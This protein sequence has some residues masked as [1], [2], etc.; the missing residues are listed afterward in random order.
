MKLCILHLIKRYATQYTHYEKHQA[1]KGVS[2]GG[3]HFFMSKVAEPI[4]Y[5][6]G[7]HRVFCH[8]YFNITKLGLFRTT[9]ISPTCRP[10]SHG[11]LHLN[12]QVSNIPTMQFFTGISRNTQL[13][14]SLTECVW[15]INLF[16]YKFMVQVFMNNALYDT[17]KHILLGYIA[18]NISYNT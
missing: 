11:Q 14:S 6:M 9:D 7:M 15:V 2:E 3:S 4:I 13:K 17:H 10:A 8:S 12:K 16:L 18:Q 1:E 5:P